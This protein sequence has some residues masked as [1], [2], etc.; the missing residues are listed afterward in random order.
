MGQ[1]V[2]LR[3]DIADTRGELAGVEFETLKTIKEPVIA[4]L[5]GVSGRGSTC[6]NVRSTSLCHDTSSYGG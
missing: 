2:I 1:E 3:V 6:A 4:A 5:S